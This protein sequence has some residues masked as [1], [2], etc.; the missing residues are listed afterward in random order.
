MRNAYYYIVERFVK[1]KGG[2]SVIGEGDCYQWQPL[3]DVKLYNHASAIRFA[4]T[5]PELPKNKSYRVAKR[6]NNDV[7][8]EVWPVL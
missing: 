4:R 6:D 7:L 1:I 3:E 8:L 2:D 5:K